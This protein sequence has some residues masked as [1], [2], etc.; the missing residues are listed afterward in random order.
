GP[1]ERVYAFP[2]SSHWGALVRDADPAAVLTIEL[3]PIDPGHP[4][5]VRTF[6]GNAGPGDG[7][8]VRVGIIDAGVGPHP[9]LTVAGGENVVPGETAADFGDNGLGHGTHVAGIVAAG[10]TPPA[11]YRGLSPAAELR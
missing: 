5:A 9:D 6:Y 8:G 10:G 2:L 7:A 4:D 3:Q 11:G 1:I